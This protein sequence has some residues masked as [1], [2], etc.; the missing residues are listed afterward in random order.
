MAISICG[1]AHAAK[2]GE[3]GLGA[4]EE[5]R[6]VGFTVTVAHSPVCYNREQAREGEESLM[7][8]SPLLDQKPNPKS[9]G[10]A[11][12]YFRFKKL[13][14]HGRRVIDAQRG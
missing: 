13:R 4:L 2:K 7:N 1:R 6:G 11:Q 3:A 12:Y 8:S 14:K 9:K 10:W 5:L